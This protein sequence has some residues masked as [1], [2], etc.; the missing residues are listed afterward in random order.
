MKTEKE[1][2]MQNFKAQIEELF[3]NFDQGV[4]NLIDLASEFIKPHKKY[5]I[6]T[7]PHSD[8]ERELSNIESYAQIK[9]I[10]ILGKEENS[11]CLSEYEFDSKAEI[12]AFIKGYQY[13]LGYMGSG[14]Y[15]LDLPEDDKDWD[16]LG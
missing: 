16:D 5:R 6:I 14:L 8:T 15:W 12:K 4:S 7:A 1:E 13:G 11:F 3:K 2:A 10:M 9:N